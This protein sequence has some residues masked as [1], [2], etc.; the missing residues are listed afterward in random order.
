[1]KGPMV[2]CLIGCALA[3]TAKKPQAPE[4]VLALDRV[5]VRYLEQIAE[6]THN[7]QA[8]CLTGDWHEGGQVDTLWLHA[9]AETPWLFFAQTDS[10]MTFIWGGCPGST[11]GFWHSHPLRTVRMFKDTLNVDTCSASP[12]DIYAMSVRPVYSIDIISIRRGFSCVF[13]KRADGKIGRIANPYNFSVSPT[14]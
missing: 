4:H 9:A 5:M 8:R 10:S 7:E 3:L 11:R 12:R 2:L 1:M 6:T 14:P 13:I